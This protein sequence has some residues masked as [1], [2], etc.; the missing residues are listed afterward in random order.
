M[1]SLDDIR[2]ALGNSPPSPTPSAPLNAQQQEKLNAYIKAQRIH[3]EA[4]QGSL[5]STRKSIEDSGYLYHYAPRSA[6][7]SILSEGLMGSK[8][9]TADVMNNGIYFFTNPNDAPSAIGVLGITG[10]VNKEN[11]GVDLYRVKVQQGMLEEMAIDAKLPIRGDV[12]SAVVVPSKS[13]SFAAELIGENARFE[14]SDELMDLFSK[15]SYD[16]I[17]PLSTNPIDNLRFDVDGKSYFLH[18]SP[19]KMEVGDVIRA[20]GSVQNNTGDA[21]RGF[22]YGYDAFNF[23]A[24]K[25]AVDMGRDVLSGQGSDQLHMYITSANAD[26]VFPDLNVA[27]GK[28]GTNVRAIKRRANSS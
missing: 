25:G 20:S 24:A 11:P 16:P 13:G 28:L 23:N 14:S 26:D 4:V 19:N 22:S 2:K 3:E 9:V 7:E 21:L 15:A 1:A 12:A 18:Y 5:S 17:K 27:Q 10:R 8:A 6:R